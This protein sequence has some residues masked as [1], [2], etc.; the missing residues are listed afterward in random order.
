MNILFLNAYFK[1]EVI[2]FTHLE[3]DILDCL[4]KKRHAVEI[5]CPVPSRGIDKKT[6]SICLPFFVFNRLF[7]KL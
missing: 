2:A 6:A 3:E 7:C 4:I 5:I 1:P